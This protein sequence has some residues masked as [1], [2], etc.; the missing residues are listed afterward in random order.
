[1]LQLSQIHPNPVRL[2]VRL[3]GHNRNRIPLIPR[4]LTVLNA[5]FGRNSDALFEFANVVRALASECRFGN[6]QVDPEV[7]Q[8]DTNWI[9]RL[10]NFDYCTLH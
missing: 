9:L 2:L 3:D 6:G 5:T 4:H 8:I 7:V 10:F 1:M